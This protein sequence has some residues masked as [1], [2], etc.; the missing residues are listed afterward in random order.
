MVPPWEEQTSLAMWN[1]PNAESVLCRLTVECYGFPAMYL[2]LSW[3]VIVGWG[4]AENQKCKIRVLAGNQR[5]SI[6]APIV[7]RSACIARR[8]VNRVTKGC[9]SWSIEHQGRKHVASM[10]CP[11]IGDILFILQRSHERPFLSWT[12]ILEFYIAPRKLY[13]D[14]ISS[15]LWEG[16]VRLHSGLDESPVITPNQSCKFWQFRGRN[17]PVASVSELSRAQYLF[18]I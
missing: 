14:S 6:L 2:G 8:T 17:E 16:H 3:Q 13:L 10:D 1:E 4:N 12:G 7:N 9:D 5:Y 18:Q 11:H 15:Q